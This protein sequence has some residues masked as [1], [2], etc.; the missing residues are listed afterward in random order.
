[1]TVKDV[2][3]PVITTNGQTIEL[4]PPNHKYK[5]IKVT[6]LVAS[7]S[8][9]CDPSVDIGSVRIAKVTSDEPENSGGDGNTT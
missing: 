9:L 5:T 6:D 7:A 2:T 1:M 4:W 3:A 8:D